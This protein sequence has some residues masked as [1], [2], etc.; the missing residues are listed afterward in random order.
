MR[1]TVCYWQADSL[2]YQDCHT[3]QAETPSIE[4]L[5]MKVEVAIKSLMAWNRQ[6]SREVLQNLS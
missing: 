3:E 1:R 5:P 2:W 6:G 4:A